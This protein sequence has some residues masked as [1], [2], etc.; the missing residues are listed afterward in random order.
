M[1]IILQLT[2]PPSILW[3]I[4]LHNA[5]YTPF[6]YDAVLNDKAIILYY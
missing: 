3:P 4:E 5:M 6:P 2:H 1:A